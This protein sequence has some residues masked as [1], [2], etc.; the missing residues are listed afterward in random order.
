MR[1]GVDQ[2]QYGYETNQLSETTVCTGMY[3]YIYIYVD[4]HQLDMNI[5]PAH[6]EFTANPLQF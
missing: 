3:T 6:C 4:I 5:C 2:Q 1:W